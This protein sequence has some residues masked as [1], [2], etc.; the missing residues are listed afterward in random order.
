MYRIMFL[1]IHKFCIKYTSYW[2]FEDLDQKSLSGDG[3]DTE[4]YFS[5][6]SL[7]KCSEIEFCV[8]EFN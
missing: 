8:Q 6:G 3:V 5:L 4:K 2:V 7:E 1:Y